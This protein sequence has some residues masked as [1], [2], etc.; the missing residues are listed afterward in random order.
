[1]LT[2]DLS[3]KED[4]VVGWRA[5]AGGATGT[6]LQI[7]VKFLFSSS[8]LDQLSK[9]CLY[10]MYLGCGLGV[11]LME[12]VRGEDKPLLRLTGA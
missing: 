12:V 6:G 5:V 10:G 11:L 8:F 7:E 2:L 9:L 1:M 4:L 3:F